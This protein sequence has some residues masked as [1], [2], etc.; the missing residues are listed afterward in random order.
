MFLGSK[1]KGYVG[2]GSD[3][4]NNFSD[5]WEWDQQ[6]DTWTQL[7]DFPGI[8]RPY[9]SGVL[10]INKAYMGIGG[11]QPYYNDWWE[12]TPD[13][14]VATAVSAIVPVHYF[15]ISTLPGNNAATAHYNL[16]KNTKLMIRNVVGSPVFSTSLEEGENTKP[17]S[18]ADFPAAFIFM[19]CRM[20][21]PSCIQEI[22]GGEVRNNF[23][24]IV[25]CQVK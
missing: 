23:N 13:S 9:G 1:E 16:D 6:S 14:S 3:Q 18:T 7:E 22:G 2:G 10:I 11:T 19:K 15:Q 17:I 4:V 21:R 20:K 24:P 5:F 12:Y 8:P 25:S